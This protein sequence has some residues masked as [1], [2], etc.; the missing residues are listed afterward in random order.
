MGTPEILATRIHFGATVNELVVE[1]V[2]IQ[3]VGDPVPAVIVPIRLLEL[4]VREGLVPQ[5]DNVGLGPELNAPIN[6]DI[7][8]RMSNG[9]MLGVC[10]NA[11]DGRKRESAKRSLII[12]PIPASRSS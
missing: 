7:K 2:T 5:F 9:P 12:P 3:E 10:A 11:A 4:A 8:F 6:T 1:N